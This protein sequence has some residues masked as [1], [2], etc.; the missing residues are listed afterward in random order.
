MFQEAP[1]INQNINP[2]RKRENQHLLEQIKRIYF[3]SRSRYGAIKIHRQSIKKGCSI[4]LKCVQR[5]MRLVG[6]TSI[7]QKKY[8]PYKR[9]KK[10]VLERHN[11]LAQG[12]LT[13]SIN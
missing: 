3:E 10:L 1:I 4:S 9:S 5:L 11:T 2:N 7:I 6:L 13:T 8:T 12:F